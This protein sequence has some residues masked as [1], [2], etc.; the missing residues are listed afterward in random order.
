VKLQ[1]DFS[2][3]YICILDVGGYASF[4]REEFLGVLKKRGASITHVNHWSQLEKPTPLLVIGS[5]GKTI[6]CQKE[7]V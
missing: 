5:K 1:F 3:L 4:G 6:R 7:S 2:A